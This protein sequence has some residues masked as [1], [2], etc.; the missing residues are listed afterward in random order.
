[1]PPEYASGLRH[2]EHHY[3]VEVFLSH[4]MKA[5]TRLATKRHVQYLLLLWGTVMTRQEDAL[6]SVRAF[7]HRGTTT[8]EIEHAALH[9][10]GSLHC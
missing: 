9:V 1:M 7:D 6:S 8:R 3:G 5:D 10:S 2:G 4:P